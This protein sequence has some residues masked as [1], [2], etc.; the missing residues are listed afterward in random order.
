MIATIPMAKFF[1]ILSTFLLLLSCKKN[2]HDPCQNAVQPSLSFNIREVVYDSSY[3]TDTMFSHN[4]VI[5][6]TVGEYD[7][8]KWNIGNDPRIFK[9]P[10]FIYG[11]GRFTGIPVGQVEIK[12]TAYK[13]PNVKC[14]PA[15]KGIYTAS[16]TLTIVDAY[17]RG[18]LTKSPLLG[19][20][21]GSNTDS[22][23]DTF[24]VRIEYFDSTKYDLTHFG[25][26][27]FYWISN[28][29]KGYF[30]DGS[31]QTYNNPELQYG[32]EINYLGYKGFSTTDGAT[33]N[34]GFGFLSHDSLIIDYGVSFANCKKRFIGRRIN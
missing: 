13:A 25:R 26:Q 28:L 33:C 2:N 5:F 16:K 23:L 32:V 27:N 31:D 29:P 9:E 4:A 12:L 18:S 10:R 20:Y 8:V 24:T 15:D 17:T 14:F 21:H 22:P 11:S 34:N 30:W 3:V 1:T 19:R 7:S 6:E